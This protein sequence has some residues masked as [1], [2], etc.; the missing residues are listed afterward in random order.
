[1]RRTVIAILAAALTSTAGFAS[2][3]TFATESKLI[4]GNDAKKFGMARFTRWVGDLDLYEE[5]FTVY[6]IERLS[7][8]QKS[9]G[10]FSVNY[11]Q[12]KHRS[13]SWTWEGE[14]EISFVAY[15]AKSY[16]TAQYF[17]P[18]IYGNSFASADLGMING[19]GKG[20][21]IKHITLFGVDGVLKERTASASFV[22]DE[23]EPVP[24]PA[25][26]LLLISGLGLMALRRR[27]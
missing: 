9:V 13:G 17:E 10:D 20:R 2:A 8:R 24:L 3:A 14:D 21:R 7:K 27:A 6:K 5:G 18:G 23:P 15:Q 12:K 25:G 22:V 11:D 19:A 26:A 1:M 16:F 4:K